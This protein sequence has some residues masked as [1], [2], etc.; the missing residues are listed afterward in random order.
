MSDR[1]QGLRDTDIR[2]VLRA[3]LLNQ[4]RGETETVLVEELGLCRGR[5]R[6]DMAVVNGVL[7][8]YE[9]KSDR[10]S[11]RR[12]ATQVGCYNKVLDRATLVVGERHFRDARS[13]VPAWWGITR[14]VAAPD[15]LAL[16]IDRVGECNPER[17]PRAI[18]ELIW[19]EDA[20][21]LLELRGIARG[22]R[23]RSRRVIWDRICEHFNLEEIAE[24]AREHIR[25]RETAY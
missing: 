16:Q 10:D 17:D 15:G 24:V 19:R 11:L 18:V 1:E 14:A 13:L 2:H 5:V 25:A 4:H 3:A 22:V 8:G 23:G 20:V 12:L 7:H 21:D 9:I 6:V